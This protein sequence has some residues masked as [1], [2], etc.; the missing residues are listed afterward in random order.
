MHSRALDQINAAFRLKRDLE[1]V[2]RSSTVTLQGSNIVVQG[3][4]WHVVVNVFNVTL[5]TPGQLRILQSCQVPLTLKQL[6]ESCYA[7]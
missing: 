1:R 2:E 6:E 3:D 5:H 7:A 4:Q